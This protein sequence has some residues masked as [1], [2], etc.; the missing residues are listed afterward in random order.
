MHDPGDGPTA[1]RERLLPAKEGNGAKMEKGTSPFGSF[2]KVSDFERI[3]ASRL[4]FIIM[5]G[6]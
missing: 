1:L 4:S 6:G 5:G 2:T 3:E